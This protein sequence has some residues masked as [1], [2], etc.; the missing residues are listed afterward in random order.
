MTIGGTATAARD[1]ARRAVG[2]AGLA[3]VAVEAVV[4]GAMLSAPPAV[5]PRARLLLRRF[6]TGEV[7]KVE[8]DLALAALVGPGAGNQRVALGTGLTL[9]FGWR[10]ASFRVDVDRS[11]DSTAA[12]DSEEG[13]AGDDANGGAGDDDTAPVRTDPLATLAASFAGSVIPE[14]GPQPRIVRFLTGPG[15]GGQSGWIR[16]RGD[17]RD[18]RVRTLLRDHPGV[19]GVLL[20]AGFVAV[21]AD[22]ERGWDVL[23]GP[24]LEC[25]ADRFVPPRP[26]VPT[27]RDLERARVE[28]GA[29][30][31]GSPRGIAKVRDALTSPDA[32]L[33]QIAVA[34]VRHDEPRH[35]EHAWRRALDDANRAVRRAAVVTMAGESL[36]ELRPLLERAL[37]D[38]DACSRFHAACGL[39][40]IG[41]ERSR[42][43]LERARGD[44]DARVRWAASAALAGRA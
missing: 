32:S 14:T 27:D 21:E 35:A 29:I 12:H 19:S 4:R 6:F 40:R 2:D 13:D 39:G 31:P 7:W 25:I 41:A 17:T 18:D 34:L 43:A 26:P 42:V 38:N 3:A 33:R 20:G 36:E 16:P 30:D 23:L 44:T 28:L 22:D 24:V 15:S 10:A 8:D 5:I 11:D 9:V 1:R 37:G